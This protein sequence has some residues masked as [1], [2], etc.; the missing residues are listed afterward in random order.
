[1]I[2]VRP[3]R[4]KRDWKTFVDLAWKFNQNDPH[5]VP[6]LRIAVH[7][8]LDVE[9]NPFFKHAYMN[10]LIAY[11]NGNP[12]GRMVGVIDENHNRAYSE[13][14]GF[15]GFFESDN[16][17]DVAAALF[18]E[19][20]TWLKGLGMNKIRG[21]MNPSTN[22]DFGLLIDGF[23][24]DPT[25]MTTHNPRYYADLVEK[26]GLAKVMDLY[27]YALTHSLK[28]PEKVL[29][30]F[31]RLKQSA[32]IHVRTINTADFDNEVGRIMD[33]YNDAW[34]D[35]W[36]FVQMDPLEIK[37]LVK[38]L[39]MIY[40]PRMVLM[41]EVDG[42]LAAFGIGLP[43]VNIA[44]KKVPNGKLFP[45]GLPK[46]LW[47][48]KGPGKKAINLLRVYGLGV[49][50]KYEKLGIGPL[51]Y[52]EYFKRGLAAGYEFGEASWILESNVP[53]RKAMERFGAPARKIW[54]IY[55]K[56]L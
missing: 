24:V 27:A 45:F 1:M 18:R 28:V 33:V 35:N 53:M 43:D 56:A 52:L 48:L 9:K 23:D 15:F 38:E 14:T 30:H 54:R 36:G 4:S 31:E 22:A 39:K 51:L 6:P 8:I 21:P 49:R 2:E 42:E 16:R 40:D 20:E 46:L 25:I 47:N 32:K 29:R 13:H 44:I 3:V 55:E 26:N 5:W 10:P 11:E 19:T 17:T 34:Q 50:K 37:Q 41:V 12:V 7:E